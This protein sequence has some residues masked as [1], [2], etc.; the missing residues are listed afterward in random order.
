MRKAGLSAL[1]RS[2][3]RSAGL[4]KPQRRIRNILRRILAQVSET[5]LLEAATQTK[6]LQHIDFADSAI[7][8]GDL[9]SVGHRR[10]GL[11]GQPAQVDAI[12]R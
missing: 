11:A 8:A 6:T 12:G 3:E 7:Q 1:V 2:A 5:Q 9:K 10:G 4:P